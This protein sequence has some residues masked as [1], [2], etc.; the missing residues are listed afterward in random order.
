M[1]AKRR[2]SIK[3]PARW[4]RKKKVLVNESDIVDVDVPCQELAVASKPPAKK[5]GRKKKEDTVTLI[6]IN[7]IL[8]TED[9]SEVQ[10]QVMINI[11]TNQIQK[12]KHISTSIQELLETSDDNL[13]SGN[14]WFKI[15]ITYMLYH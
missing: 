2:V 14:L 4:G 15:I 3:A 1:T 10:E 8:N 9:T 13:S 7:D 11:P 5:W 12:K 6:P